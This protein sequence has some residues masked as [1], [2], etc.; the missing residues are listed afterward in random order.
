AARRRR[1]RPR[2]AR[3]IRERGERIMTATTETLTRLHD[4]LV[5]AAA[6]EGILDIAYRTLETPVG[7]LLVAASP[8]GVVRVAFDSEGHDRALET[9]AA[10]V[11]PR[12]LEAPARLDRVARE[13]EEYFAGR[14]SSFEVAVDF[15]LASGFRRE[16]LE[17]LPRI[18]YG[19]TESYAHVAA[20]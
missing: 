1:R 13:L 14:R 18:P 2:P 20:A 5:A 19:E 17:H 8:R 6:E 4:R 3:P 12:I 10:R 9:L 16:V 7:R 15:A 11:S